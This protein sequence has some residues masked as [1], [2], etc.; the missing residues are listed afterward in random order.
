MTQY[1]SLPSVTILGVGKYTV[2][3]TGFKILEE[4]VYH[5][6]S[7][8]NPQKTVEMERYKEYSDNAFVCVLTLDE[9]LAPN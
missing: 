7:R 6:I 4:Y 5:V 9:I 8:Y 1:I 2:R 3:D